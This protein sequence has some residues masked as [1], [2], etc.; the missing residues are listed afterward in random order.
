MP[1]QL[2]PTL[3]LQIPLSSENFI[4]LEEISEIHIDIVLPEGGTTVGDLIVS[5]DQDDKVDISLRVE[6]QNFN[7]LSQDTVLDSQEYYVYANITPKTGY[8]LRSDDEHGWYAVHTYINGDDYEYS[9]ARWIRFIQPEEEVIEEIHIEAFL[10]EWG[11]TVGDI[12]VTSDQD[13]KAYVSLMYVRDQYGNE[14]MEDSVIGEEEYEVAF[15]I[16]PRT[17]YTLHT[18][19]IWIIRRKNLYQR[20]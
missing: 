19:G 2:T 9:F 1:G 11:S 12:S 16:I 15:E 14:L 4:E 20:K 17:G 6:D 7:E 3:S 18:E 8:K 5:S 10:P 13:D